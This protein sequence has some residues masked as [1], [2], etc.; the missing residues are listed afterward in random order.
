MKSPSAETIPSDV[1]SGWMARV[2]RR[3]VSVVALG[4]G[5]TLLC[6]YAAREV[7]CILDQ[8]REITTAAPFRRMSVRG[9]SM[10]V[11]MTNCG[12]VGWVT[13]STGYRYNP[14]ELP[15]P[16]SG[17]L[18]CRRRSFLGRTRCGGGR[19]SAFRA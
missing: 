16:D 18:R 2:T 14:V 11:G 12:A 1:Q 19:L 4:K 3:E 6:G 10:S 7:G 5:V 9:G 15:R 17:G 13:D 8:V